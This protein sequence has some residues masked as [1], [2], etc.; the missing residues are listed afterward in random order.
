M[1]RLG[2]G[3]P[4]FSIAFVTSCV[5]IINFC[6]LMYR[7]GCT[8]LWAGA[9]AR[10]NIHTPGVRHCPWCE[11]GGAGFALVLGS[12]IVAQAAACFAAASWGWPARLAAGLAAFPA[13]AGVTA[14]VVGWAKGYWN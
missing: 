9:D 10:C 14:L 2:A 12:V 8:F 6:D 3:G 13:S 5:F 11:M 1:S 4:A 7:C